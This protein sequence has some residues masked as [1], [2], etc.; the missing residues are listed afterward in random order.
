MVWFDRCGRKYAYDIVEDRAR[1]KSRD[2]RAVDTPRPVSIP[3]FPIL[4]HLRSSPQDSIQRD[5]IVVKTE[6][7]YFLGFS[8]KRPII[9]RRRCA[10]DR[11]NCLSGFRLMRSD[12]LFAWE[13]VVFF[14]G[15]SGAYAPCVLY[16]LA[17]SF[18]HS[19]SFSFQPLHEHE[20]HH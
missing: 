19:F 5:P 12:M 1:T 14:S 7:S 13:H 17:C 16:Q 18:T 20:H 4:S 11:C 15:V 3:G 9:S 2:Q 8:A 10:A 6:S